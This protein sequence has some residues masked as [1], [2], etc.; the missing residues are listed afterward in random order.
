MD[1]EKLPT[2]L[3]CFRAIRAHAIRAEVGMTE[4]MT[5]K[6]LNM[7]A[8]AITMAA[9]TI[10]ELTAPPPAPRPV[11]SSTTIQVRGTN[12]APGDNSMLTFHHLV[13]GELN[14]TSRKD[15]RRK[16]DRFTLSY[17]DGA[18]REYRVALEAP[19][20]YDVDVYRSNLGVHGHVRSTLSRNGLLGQR[21]TI[22]VPREARSTLD[23]MR[24]FNDELALM[25]KSGVI[26]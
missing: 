25:E 18:G 2:I 14:A 16:V 1:P 6:D 3:A 21:G 15:G 5:L 20:G 24:A 23:I 7:L 10:E 4:A 17:Q 26:Q 13:R 9:A 22:H 8:K 11:S 12:P 19:R